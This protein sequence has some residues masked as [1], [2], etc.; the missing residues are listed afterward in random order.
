MPATGSIHGNPMN[1]AITFIASTNSS[2]ETDQRHDGRERVH[3][4]VP[5]IRLQHAAV[6]L[7]GDLHGLV[8]QPLLHTDGEHQNAHAHAVEERI[9][10]RKQLHSVRV[11]GGDLRRRLHGFWMRE[12]Q[13]RQQLIRVS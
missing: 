5:R 8:V 2:G 11:R 4:V 1:Y 6:R 9:I 3:A 13:R 7:H 12:V 10:R